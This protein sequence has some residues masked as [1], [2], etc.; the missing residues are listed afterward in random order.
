MVT[1]STGCQGRAPDKKAPQAIDG[2]LDLSGWDFER[3]GPVKLDGQWEF[4]W[5]QLLSPE[6]FAGGNKIEK[7]GYMIVPG[8]WNGYLIKGD[9]LGWNGCATLRLR[10]KT[11]SLPGRSAI[12][13]MEIQTAYKLWVNGQL[14]SSNG[15][16]GRN[17]A[18]STGQILPRTDFF[19]VDGDTM[20]IVVQTSEFFLHNGQ[21]RSVLLGTDGQMRA[22]RERQL[23]V[24]LFLFGSALIIGLYHMGFFLL[25]RKDPSSLYFSLFCLSI[26]LRTV[27]VG[28][29]YFVNLFP[30]IEMEIFI[31][32]AYLTFVASLPLMSMFIRFLYAQEVNIKAVRVSQWAALVF[33]LAILFTPNKIYDYLLVPYELLIV[34]V[35]SYLFVGLIRAALRGKEGAALLLCGLLALFILA[36][37]DMLWDQGIIQTG[38]MVHFGLLI[39]I[40]TQ[41]IVLAMRFQ[42]AFA[43]VESLSER[44]LSLDRLKDEFLANTSHELRTPLNGIIGLAESLQEGA[45]GRVSE[46]MDRNLGMIAASGRRLA[47]LINDILDYSKLKHRDIQLQLKPLGI[48]EVAGLVLAL[49]R[50]LAGQKELELVN[51]IPAGLPPAEADENR[52]QQILYNLVGNAVKYTEAGR[53]EIDAE[54]DGPFLRVMVSDTGIGIPENQFELIFRSFEQGD[55]SISRQYG[56][57]GIGLAL[58]KRLV[59]LHGGE[60]D[61]ESEVGRGSRFSF[62]L[63]LA[64]AAAAGETPAVA[65]GTAVGSVHWVSGGG[66]VECP[67]GPDCDILVVDDDPVNLQ[68]MVNLLSLQ[69]YNV[70]TAGGGID[71]LLL[72]EAGRRPGLVILDVMMPGLNGYEVC[73]KIR[74]KYT[75]TELPVLLLTAGN[76]AGDLLTGFEAGANDYLTK[77][78][79]RQEMLARVKTLLEL[80]R[81]MQRLAEALAQLEEH[82]R[83][84]EQGV[85]EKAGD[86]ERTS[87]QLSES[88]ERYKTIFENTGTAMLIFNEDLTILRVNSQWEKL[89]GYTEKETEG[90]TW[91]DY[92]RPEDLEKFRAGSRADGYHREGVSRTFEGRVKNKSGEARDVL[93]TVSP[94]PGARSSIASL[95]DISERKQAEEM[96]RH[97]AYHDALTGLPNR[98]FFQERLSQELARA[99]RKGE[100]LAVMFLDLDDYKGVNDSH[101]HEVGDRLLCEVAGRLKGALRESDMASRLGGDE[102]TL[103]LTDIKSRADVETVTRKIFRALE[104][105]ADIGGRRLY[106]RASLGVSIYPGDGDS[107][108]ELL[109]K[110]DDA[111]YLAKKAGKN[112][113]QFYAAV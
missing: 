56:G 99:G 46:A 21:I 58:T 106:I 52:L 33:I 70:R 108:D 35:V 110:A 111:M 30:G 83:R 109:R 72:L 94:I 3:D 64:K 49:T 53:V 92:I 29:R 78:F 55:G 103:L 82:S 101:G 104:E 98:K 54:V 91:E 107:A 45:A 43:T 80:G 24:E 40:F 73:R 36:V 113:C 84:L 62:T 67:G 68:V 90:D 75:A 17:Q 41:S 42:R 59:E 18:E 93:F 61:M 79:N 4:Y 13:V 77:P 20:E 34:L 23:A 88:E 32:T 105:P 15:T 100:R 60:I 44:L 10:V 1:A 96:V 19:S 57:T 22:I 38:S 89:L 16:V 31:K 27:L 85:Q 81:T 66:P 86:L 95:I 48:R 2:V 11:G 102:F 7:N 112:S 87:R 6:A 76:R 37:N 71:A 14:V 9:K 69:K 26:A 97:M 5:N 51:R 63:P 50:P 47:G 12:R 39:F 8:K 25:R 28:E 74:E 65:E